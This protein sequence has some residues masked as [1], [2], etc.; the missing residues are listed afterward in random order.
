MILIPGEAESRVVLAVLLAASP[1]FLGGSC[2]ALPPGR[3]R[4][5]ITPAPV[6]YFGQP[7]TL[8]NN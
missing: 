1:Q 8:I 2:L 7:A 4:R 5:A 3:A 6:S